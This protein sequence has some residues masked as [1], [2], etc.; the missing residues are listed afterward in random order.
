MYRLLIA[1]RG[2]PSDIGLLRMVGWQNVGEVPVQGG[3]RFSKQNAD[4]GLGWASSRDIAK[5]AHNSQIK[6]A[7]DYKKEPLA[8]YNRMG[9]DS[10]N[11]STPPAQSLMTHVNQLPLS[12]QDKAAFDAELRD[13]YPQWVGLDDPNAMDKLMGQGGFKSIGKIRTAFT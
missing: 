6:M 12:K 1:N 8:V 9:D 4:Q 10:T 3:Y 2:D 5:S 13:K 11:F 7:K